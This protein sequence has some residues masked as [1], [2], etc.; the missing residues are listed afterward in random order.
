MH[1]L[2]P[3]AGVS[4]GVSI[5]DSARD[6]LAT[7]VTLSGDFEFYA[8]PHPGCWT[9]NVI[10]LEL[11]MEGGSRSGYAV[12]YTVTNPHEVEVGFALQVG[13]DRDVLER[14]MRAA[15]ASAIQDIRFTRKSNPKK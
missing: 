13:P 15:A 8:S 14:A 5:A 11:S 6:P 4:A 9:V 10:A 7:A 3:N 12:A 1:S 2:E